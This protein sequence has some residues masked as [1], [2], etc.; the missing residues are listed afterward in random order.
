MQVDI[1]PSNWSRALAENEKTPSCVRVCVH[2]CERGSERACVSVRACVCVRVC[3]CVCVC[4]RLPKRQRRFERTAHRTRGWL[5]A[6]ADFPLRST[7]PCAL[8]STHRERSLRSRRE[9]K[10]EPATNC[11][12]PQRAPV[13]FVSLCLY[14]KRY[15]TCDLEPV[16]G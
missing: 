4:D 7:E 15:S 6:S 5:R 10:R 1:E 12:S 2:A 14:I 11:R 9:T 13:R 3:M 8:L 16:H